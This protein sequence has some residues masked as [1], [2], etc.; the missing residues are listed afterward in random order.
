M[1][2]VLLENQSNIIIELSTYRPLKYGL[3]VDFSTYYGFHTQAIGRSGT[4]RKFL[5]KTWRVTTDLAEISASLDK[6]FLDIAF[7]P[8][9]QMSPPLH[10]HF[11]SLV[12]AKTSLLPLPITSQQ[13]AA[14]R[15]LFRVSVATISP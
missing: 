13:R 7:S 3:V 15:L 11:H 1:G 9:S 4:P 12:P 8:Y 6:I 2:L 14:I 10:P 5:G